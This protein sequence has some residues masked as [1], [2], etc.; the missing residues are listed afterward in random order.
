MPTAPGGSSGGSRKEKAAAMRAEMEA[1]QRSHASTTV[2]PA[3]SR[4]QALEE[5]VQESDAQPVGAGTRVVRAGDCVASIAKETG[6]FW[7]TIWEDSGNEALREVRG[8]PNVLL[9]GD[10]VVVP[11]VRPKDE[12]GATEQRHR[13]VRR[14]EP[15][16]VILR[17]LVWPEPDEA[18]DEE[19]G[20]NSPCGEHDGDDPASEPEQPGE[21]VPLGNAPYELEVDGIVYPGTTD[22][23]GVLR[24]A[25]APNV[26]R[27]VARVRHGEHMLEYDLRLGGVDPIDSITGLQQRL[28]NLAFDSGPVDGIVG[29]LTRG[30]IRRFQSHCGL[31]VTGR[32]DDQTRR[33]LLDIH[34]S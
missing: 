8:N 17:I 12:E 20:V 23:E 27:A 15:A 18:S 32:A 13:F 11:P 9:P 31:D 4:Q 14:G 28:N 1:R 30:A 25:V 2:E 6:H 7:E 16:M 3:E 22:A 29:P 24:Q 33:K 19:E 26:R 10:R 5:D 34:G 21:K